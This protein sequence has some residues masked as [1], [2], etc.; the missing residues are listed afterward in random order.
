[1]YLEKLN[2]LLEQTCWGTISSLHNWK[3]VHVSLDKTLNYIGRFQKISIPVP[4]TAFKISEGEG[5]FT[6]M[7]FWGHGGYLRLE[8]W[9]HG[10]ISQ[11]EFLEYKV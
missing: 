4:R 10:E 9:R 3:K 5:G 2:F 11:V 6:I 8:I 1:M 7:E